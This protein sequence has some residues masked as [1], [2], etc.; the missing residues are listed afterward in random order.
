M[1]SSIGLILEVRISWSRDKGLNRTLRS[2]QHTSRRQGPGLA[3]YGLVLRA[4]V[5]AL[6]QL[7]WLQQAACCSVPQFPHP[8]VG[9]LLSCEVTKRVVFQGLQVCRWQLKKS[10]LFQSLRK[11]KGESVRTG[12][13]LGIF[14]TIF[15]KAVGVKVH[16]SSLAEV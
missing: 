15:G 6:N 14:Y 13:S 9:I 5:D 12:L 1:D 10:S 3:V 8:C 4:Q 16:N 2:G 11:D 7:L